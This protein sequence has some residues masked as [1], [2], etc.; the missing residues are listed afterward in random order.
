MFTA[1]RPLTMFG[2]FLFLA[3]LMLVFAFPTGAQDVPTENSLMLSEAQINAALQAEPLPAGNELSVDLQPGQI[4]IIWMVTGQRGN[5]TT[6]ALTLVP[7]ISTEGDLKFDA[8][9]L[10]LN[11]TEININNNQ[12]IL[13]TAN[14]MDAVLSEQTGGAL[15]QSVAVSDTAIRLTWV[16]ENPNDPIITIQDSLFSLTFTESSIN[17]MD[18]VTQ[19]TGEFV[20]AV[21]VDLQPRQAVINVTRTVEPILVSYEIIPT[22]VNGYVAWQ[23]NANADGAGSVANTLATVWQA[24]F[25]GIYGDGSMIN[26]IVTDHTITFTWDLTNEGM[27]EDSVVTYNVNEADINAALAQYLPEELT[28]LSIDMQPGKIILNAAGV[29]A[30]GNPYQAAITLVPILRNGN[31]TWR[32]ESLIYNGFV[33][34]TAQLGNATN[35][36]TALTSGINTN[37]RTGT[38]TNLEITDTDLTFTVVYR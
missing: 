22:V 14:T 6:F 5:T 31:L 32:I 19:P 13:G 11:G 37:R 8:V 4:V 2:K 27:P 26:A 21:S 10:T 9:R 30:T 24:Y 25:G 28:E 33:V 38:I 3:S 20:N 15:L 23:V 16:N 34:D 17:Q 1:L 18:W 7:Y 35:A 36:T 29:D 12:A